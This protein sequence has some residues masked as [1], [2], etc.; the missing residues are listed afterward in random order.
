MN[1]HVFTVQ[2]S[3]LHS[4][5]ANVVCIVR[6]N[7]GKENRNTFFDIVAGVFLVAHMPS[8]FEVVL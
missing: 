2:Q 8:T 5:V 7:I 6:L 4:A 3:K 1:E